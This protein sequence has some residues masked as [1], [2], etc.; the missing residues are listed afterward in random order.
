MGNGTQQLTSSLL[1]FNDWIFIES[2]VGNA[3]W[4]LGKIIA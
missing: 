4:S 3:M 2:V 1:L